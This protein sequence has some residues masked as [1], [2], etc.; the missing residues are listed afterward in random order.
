M[1]NLNSVMLGSSQPKELAEFY[2]KVFDK[3]ADYADEGDW[4]GFQI[5]SCFLNVGPHSEVTGSAAEPQ[6]I[7]MNI[8][9]DDVDNEFERI[10]AAGATVIAEPY[11]MDGWEGGKIA[12][13]ADPDGNYFQLM[14]P[15]DP[16]DMAQ[17]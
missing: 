5:G 16:N 17:A 11:S 15:F 1:L 4:Y 8:E 3:E 2:K 7:I 12:T 10:K 14:P 13:F 6:R 9:C